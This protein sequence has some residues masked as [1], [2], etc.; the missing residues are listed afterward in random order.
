MWPGKTDE[1]W[2]RSPIVLAF[3][4]CFHSAQQK[5]NLSWF[6]EIQALTFH[7]QN[8]QVTS[9]VIVAWFSGYEITIFTPELHENIKKCHASNDFSN[10]K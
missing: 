10:L 8:S 5:I 3:A 6:F 1:L 7:R 2:R 4:V 9:C